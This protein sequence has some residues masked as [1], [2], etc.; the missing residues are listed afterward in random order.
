MKTFFAFLKLLSWSATFAVM[1]GGALRLGPAALRM[2]FERPFL[3]LRTLVAVWIAVPALTMLVVLGLR[4]DGLGATTLLLMAG[5]PGIPLL[6]GTTR[7]V[8][9]GMRT[10]FVALVLTAATEPL[11]IPYWTRIVSG[12]LPIDLRVQPTHILQVL[13]PT[14]FVPIA[15]AF[16]L[17]VLSPRVAEILAPIS[18]WVYVVGAV[19]CSLAI[20][21]EAAPIVLRIPERTFVA[22]VIITL[23]DAL[24]GYVAGWPDHEDQKAIALAAALGNPALA[25][26]VAEVSYPE[27]QAGPLV[28]AYLL[29][30]AIALAPF[31]WWLKR[32]KH[33]ALQRRAAAR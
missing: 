31:E 17:R 23:G 33:P 21:I 3:S 28:A 11:L 24:I 25:L 15:L 13:V 5:C 6:L 10:A 22:A 1:F 14:I 18:D 29:V 32:S 8:R 16:T 7:K 30:R 12:F 4:V 19:G 27:H 26:A 20:V 2:I 9:G